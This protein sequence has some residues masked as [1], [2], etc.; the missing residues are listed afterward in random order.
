MVEMYDG[1]TPIVPEN[2]FVHKLACLR[3]KVELGDLCIVLPGA[4]VTGDTGRIRI[5]CQTLI[6]E[7]CVIH[8]GTFEQWRLGL[9]SVL[10]IGN[11]VVLGHGAVIH[12]R[13]IG[14][15]TLI[16]MNAT[17]LEGAEIGSECVIAAGAVVTENMIVPNRSFVAGV[18]AKIRGAVTD[19]H[20]DRA[21]VLAEVSRQYFTDTIRRLKESVVVG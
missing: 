19:K 6:E 5:G 14:S 12:A 15:H 13:S 17:V 11:N 3:G 9:E 18:P 2:C 1:H 20:M 10:D 4:S 16:G 7:N 8:A 21:H